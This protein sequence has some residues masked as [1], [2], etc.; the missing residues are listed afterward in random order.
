METQE[1]QLGLDLKRQGIARVAENNE[2]FLEHARAI[3]R[4]YAETHN[5]FVTSDD[6]RRRNTLDPE[7]PNAWG[8]VFAGKEW[9]A[10]GEWVRSQKESNHGR[11][12]KVWR[13]V[14]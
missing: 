5:G 6:V 13:Y 11:E 3:A 10:T 7:H 9:V 1:G 2:E 8:A 12:I 14:G 4:D